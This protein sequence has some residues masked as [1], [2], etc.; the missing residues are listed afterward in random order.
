MFA[1]C[2]LDSGC[3]IYLVPARLGTCCMSTRK[4]AGRRDGQAG[5]HSRTDGQNT[6]VRTDEWGYLCG[7]RTCCM[8]TRR[9]LLKRSTASILRSWNSFIRDF[10]TQSEVIQGR[11]ARGQSIFAAWTMGYI[12][13]FMRDIRGQRPLI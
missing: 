1:A 3:I 4:P 13:S 10:C 6:D 7:C 2:R 8:S 12:I 5:R 9:L 11:R